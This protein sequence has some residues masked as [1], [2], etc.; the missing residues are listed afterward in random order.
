MD[1]VEEVARRR[2][3]IALDDP[4]SAYP[5]IRDLLERRMSF[6]DVVEE[7][8]YNDVDEGIIRTRIKTL[9]FF[10]ARSREELEIY[11]YISK[12]ERE[13]DIQIKAK[14]VTEYE[15]DLKWKRSLWYY[16]YLSLY[17]KLLYGK[18]RHKYV[19]AVEG[20]ADQLLER[21]RNNVEVD[22]SG[23]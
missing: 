8:Y 1:I 15:V 5:E 7:R 4:H 20:K 14:V 12:P 16:A 18:V 13:L 6:D 2:T 3:T 22:H 17:D 21:V 9:E 11:I 10:D 19:D 23:G